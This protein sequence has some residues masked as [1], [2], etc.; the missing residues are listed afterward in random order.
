MSLLLLLSGSGS[1]VSVPKPPIRGGTTGG[2]TGYQLDQDWVD[3][4][5][6]RHKKYDTVK[7]DWEVMEI[8]IEMLLSGTLH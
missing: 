2:G 1:G 5:D 8:I 4:Y 6:K 3:R 7:D